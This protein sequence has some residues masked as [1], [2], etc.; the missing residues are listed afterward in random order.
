MNNQSSE[1]ESIGL[2]TPSTLHP[3]DDDNPQPIRFWQKK[4]ERYLLLV[5]RKATQERYARALERFLGVHPGKTYPHEFLRPV[6]YDYVKNRLA[7]GASVATVRLEMSA[8][9][10]LFEF[11]L[12][13][14]AM[15]VFPIRQKV[16]G[17]LGQR[18]SRQ[19]ATP[20]K[21]Q[22]RVSSTGTS[23]L[24]F[25]WFGGSPDFNLKHRNGG[26]DGSLRVKET[27]AG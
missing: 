6:M 11:M 23:Q 25:W 3:I 22:R 5:G 24:E 27:Q 14:E 16:S 1:N 19:S 7:E 4:Y 12:R 15:G 18:R 13:M 21:T 8:V 10:G 9:R 20:R 26:D 17:C 2:K